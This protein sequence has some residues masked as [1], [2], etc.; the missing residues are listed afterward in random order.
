MVVQ[1]KVHLKRKSTS[2]FM[3]SSS[4]S[5]SSSFNETCVNIEDISKYKKIIIH[6]K[7]QGTWLWDSFV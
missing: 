1:K 7:E 4:S 6:K 3:L 2:H 5:S